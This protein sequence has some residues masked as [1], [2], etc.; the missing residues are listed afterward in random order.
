MSES[1][2]KY[3]YVKRLSTS[4]EATV[5]FDVDPFVLKGYSELL[6]DKKLLKDGGPGMENSRE[7]YMGHHYVTTT[8]GDIYFSQLKRAKSDKRKSII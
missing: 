2:L 8:Q 4:Q 6:L 3:F 7:V 5:Y 1:L